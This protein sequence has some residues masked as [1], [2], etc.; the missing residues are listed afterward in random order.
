MPEKNR[1]EILK[2]ELAVNLNRRSRVT[3][4]EESEEKEVLNKYINATPPP[5]KNMS[6]LEHN[7]ATSK[8]NDV[9]IYELP[10]V[11]REQPG[12]NL[13]KKIDIRINNFPEE[14]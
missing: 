7:T 8:L 10:K 2:K 12:P 6:L 14:K 11:W 4:R 13:E 9:Y 3:E 5:A 1:L